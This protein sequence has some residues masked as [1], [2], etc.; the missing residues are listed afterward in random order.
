MKLSGKTQ[1]EVEKEYKE[2]LAQQ[3]RQERD[4]RINAIRWRLERY[5]DEKRLGFTPT[6][7]EDTIENILMYVQALRDVPQQDGFPE[8]IDWPA[9]P[10][11]ARDVL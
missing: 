5:E 11:E 2:Y 8:K 1:A 6:D 7:S 10:Q 3:A 4:R 9:E